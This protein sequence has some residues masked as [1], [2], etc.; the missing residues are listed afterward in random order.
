[1]LRVWLVDDSFTKWISQT[2]QHIESILEVVLSK[3]DC[4]VDKM[5]EAMSYAVLGQ[6]KRLRPLLVYATGEIFSAPPL[7]CDVA[8][9]AVELIHSYSLVHDDLPAIDNASVRRGK[10]SCFKA[11][12]EDMAILVG[13]ALQS[14]A[15]N[16]L[17][18]STDISPVKQLAMIN[19]L[20]ESSGGMVSGQ[21]LDILNLS[22]SGYT[23]ELISNMYL[24]KTGSLFHAS[25][26]LGMLSGEDLDYEINYSESLKKYANF[27]ALAFQIQDDIL[28]IIGEEKVTGKK[29]GTD[30]INHKIT[31]PSLVGITAAEEKVKELILQA[32]QELDIFAEKANKLRELTAYLMNRSS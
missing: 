26:Q 22:T 4:P 32:M 24:L 11:F 2:R 30:F 9:Q 21:V 29:S 25:V 14:L 23:T 17:S 5:R 19:I 15:F 27:L 10:M 13:D 31:Y 12:G 20:S 18:Q 6:S 3:V 28:D 8:A 7:N 1:M 16:I